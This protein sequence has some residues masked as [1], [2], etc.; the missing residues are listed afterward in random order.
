[1]RAEGIKVLNIG[2]IVQRS[3]LMLVAK[4]S[5]EIHSPQDLQ[6]RKVGLWGPLFQ[7]QPRAF[8]R[9]YNIVVRE[10]SQAYSVNLFLWD[11]VDVASAMWYNEYHTIVN[12][13]INP[14][15]LSTFYFH[16][17]GLNFPEDGIY[18]L[19]RTCRED[20]DLCRD[21]VDASIEGWQYAFDHPDEALDVVMGNLKREHIP[22]NRI[23]QKWML[24]RMKDLI[25]PRAE[26][27]GMGRLLAYDYERVGRGLK[28]S[29]IIEVI[30]PF[31]DF[32]RFY[33]TIH[34]R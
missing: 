5:R 21:F 19:D 33:D 16:E 2:Q 4:K 32:H 26:T 7:V 8:F 29:G 28:E 9:K 13:G 22:A 34:Q 1:M 18:T 31:G 12:A 27:M 24:D 20:P 11:G 10:V 14:E 15:E 23:H 3:A 17:H 25:L 30:P 6:N